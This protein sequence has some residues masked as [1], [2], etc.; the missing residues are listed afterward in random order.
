MWAQVVNV[1]LGIWL[2]VAPAV[3][4]YV[5][6]ARTHDL[7]IGPLV[8]S[9]A[10]IACWEATRAVR[11]VNLPLGLWLLVAPWVLGFGWVALFNSGVVGM[12]VASCASI[13][14]PVR[15]RFG[16]GWMSLTKEHRD[17]VVMD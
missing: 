15:Q 17:H 12:L 11:W 3:L 10:L 9:F 14:G 2:M 13:G 7:I 1:G 5:G 16:G 4:E 8:A 6:T